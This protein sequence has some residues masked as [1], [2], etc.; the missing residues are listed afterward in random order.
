MSFNRNRPFHELNLEGLKIHSLMAPGTPEAAHWRE[1]VSRRILQ[2]WGDGERVLISSHLMAPKPDASWNW[3]E[4]DDKRVSWRDFHQFFGMLEITP[5]TS[6][7]GEFR[8]LLPTPRNRNVLQGVG[9]ALP[10]TAVP[11]ESKTDA[12]VATAAPRACR[13]D[14]KARRIAR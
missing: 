5:A 9:S 7:Q 8:E 14:E 10:D 11:A 12:S 13:V 4:G 1:S 6:G 3:V 2:A